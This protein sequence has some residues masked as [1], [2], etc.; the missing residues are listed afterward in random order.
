MVNILVDEAYAFDYLAILQLKVDKG[1]MDQ[2]DIDQDIQFVKLQVGPAMY[3]K[4]VSS[5]IYKQL[6]DANVKTFDAVDAAKE[7]KILASEVDRCNYGRSTAK[8]MLQ[9]QFFDSKLRE[10]KIGYEKLK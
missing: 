9:E 7:D 4:V 8:K 1:Y 2:K 10:T 6:Y 3:N 5:S